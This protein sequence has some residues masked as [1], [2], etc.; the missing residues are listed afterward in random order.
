MAPKRKLEEGGSSGE[1]K[2]AKDDESDRLWH[3]RELLVHG[4]PSSLA[5]QICSTSAA[6]ANHGVTE[7]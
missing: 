6:R 3:L 1:K 4:M 7:L 5:R 2:K